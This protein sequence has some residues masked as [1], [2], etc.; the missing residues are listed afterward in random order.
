MKKIGFISALL[1][2]T[3]TYAAEPEFVFGVVDASSAVQRIR[4]V[5]S[6]EFSKNKLNER[7]CWQVHNLPA[8]KRLVTIQSELIAPAITSF[9]D[10][11]G[12]RINATSIKEW[13]DLEVI[14]GV[15]GTCGFFEASDPTGQ[16]ILNIMVDGKRYPAQTMILK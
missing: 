4:P 6:Y 3:M 2:S 11:D 7:F 1:L 12:N 8:N 14:E 16:Y 13:T 5:Q 9:L 15:V 10:K